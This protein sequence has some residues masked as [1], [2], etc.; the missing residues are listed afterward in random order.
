MK[1]DL[2]CDHCDY[3]ASHR[4]E[5]VARRMLGCHKSKVHGIRGTSPS[6][7]YARKKRNPVVNS[8]PLQESSLDTLLKNFSY[9]PKCGV[10]LDKW[11]LAAI[12]ISKHE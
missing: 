5:V 11:I 6:S 12:A 8:T 4:K 7:R 1:T 2:K 10:S 9:C 3:V